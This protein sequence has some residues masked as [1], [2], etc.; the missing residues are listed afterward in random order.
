MYAPTYDRVIGWLF[1]AGGI[2]GLLTP[3]LGDYVTFTPIDT[4]LCLAIGLSA[5]AAARSRTRNAAALSL[6]FGVALLLWGLWGLAWPVSILGI[7]EPLET[8]VR[9]VGGLW[10][11]Y[12]AMHDVNEWRRSTA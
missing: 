1:F 8:M 10:G 11:M 6:L 4:A 12:V 9:I 5:M 2:A 7:T 3:R